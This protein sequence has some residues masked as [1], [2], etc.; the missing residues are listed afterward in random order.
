MYCISIQIRPKYSQAFD[1]QAFLS[2]VRRIR[3][4]EIDAEEEK[5][6]LF[7]SF[8]FFTEFP[9]AL[10]EDL[11]NALYKDPEYGELISEQ[12]L[13][14][15]EDDAGDCLLLHHYDVSEKLDSL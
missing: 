5:G 3:S 15:C 2:R 11:A 4:P 10:W 8:N 13:A 1:Q 9:K 14:I 6:K 7:L 12:S